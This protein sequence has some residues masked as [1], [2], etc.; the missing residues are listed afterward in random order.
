MV[1]SQKARRAKGSIKKRNSYGGVFGTKTCAYDVSL[2]GLKGQNPKKNGESLPWHQ[3][4]RNIDTYLNDKKK[5][6]QK[7][8]ANISILE[9]SKR[10]WGRE[11]WIN[12]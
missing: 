7:I 5:I 11:T 4:K 10:A 2:R 8:L 1:R 12:I 9:S 3:E 6:V